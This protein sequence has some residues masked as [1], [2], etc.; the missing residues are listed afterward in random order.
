MAMLLFGAAGSG[1]RPVTGIAAVA[2]F[3]GVYR[4]VLVVVD[5]RLQE[6]IDSRSRATVTSVAGLGIDLASFGLYAVWALG[7]VRAVAVAGLLLAVTLPRML[8]M[9]LRRGGG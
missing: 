4:A 9:P 3:Y 5:A 1:A 8:R 7:E 2:V 6:R